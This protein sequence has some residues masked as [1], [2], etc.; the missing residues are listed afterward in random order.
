MVVGLIGCGVISRAYLKAMEGFPVLTPKLVADQDPAAAEKCATEFNLK[1]VSVEQLLGDPQIEIV[2]NLTTP[3][4]HVE[5]G[6]AAIA[7][8]KHI[9][10]EKPLGI[11]TAEAKQLIQE[12]RNSG[13]RV[14]CAP[15]TFLGAG[16]QTARRLID[17][18]AIGQPIGGTAFLML[19]G[20]ERWHPNPAFYYEKSGGGPMMDMGPYYLTNL[21]QLL[22]PVS[23]VFAFGGIFRDKREIAT[24][25]LAGQ[26]FPVESL[27]HIVGSLEFESGALIQITTSFEVYAHKHQP[28]EIYGDKGSILIPDPNVFGGDV[29][30]SGPDQ[31][32]H[33][34]SQ[35]HN[36]EDGNFRSIGLADMAEAIRQDRPHR[37]NGDLAFHVLD[38]MQ[39]LNLSA[40]NP[41]ILEIESTAVRPSP[42]AFREIVG[43]ASSR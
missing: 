13:L 27:T 7:A 31:E 34:V 3:A 22:G 23:R 2:L 32:W 10:S 30:V 16:H 38:I 42:L 29:E 40:E 17:E 24:G 8:G 14:G 21:I 4:S 5:I 15:D 12:A 19:P 20:H 11:G 39:A 1:A 26:S 25:P 18:D 35:K 41:G 37:A 43:A 33:R 28:I 36:Y 9:Y 6:L